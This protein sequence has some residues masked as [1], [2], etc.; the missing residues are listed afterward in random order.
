MTCQPPFYP[1]N[2]SL[3]SSFFILYGYLIVLTIFFRVSVETLP[4]KE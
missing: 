1:E 3:F 2:I 4:F